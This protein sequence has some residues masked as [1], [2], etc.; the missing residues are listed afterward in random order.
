MATPIGHIEKEVIFNAVHEEKIPVL[1]LKDRV[2][3]TLILESPAG[4]ELT[5]RPD[6]SVGK[7]K[8]HS[9]LS[10]LVNYHGQ[11]VDFAVE[12]MAQNNDTLVCRSP[13]VLHKNLD[14]NYIRVDAPADLKI[15]FTFQGDRYDLSLP[16]INEYENVTAEDM[17]RGMDP[18]NLSGLVKQITNSMKAFSDGYKIVNFKDKQPETIEEKILS[19]TGK[20]LFIPSTTGSFPK[21]DPYPKKRL[22]TEEIFKQYLENTGVGKNFLDENVM[23]FL[24]KRADKGIYSDAW[25]PI[26]FQEYV[27]GYIRVWIENKDKPIFNLNVLDSVFQYSKVLAFSLKENGYFEHGR[28]KGETIQSKVLDISVSGLLFAYP[29]GSTQLDALS[30]GTDLKVGIEAPNRTINVVAKIARR[31][32]DRSAGYLGCRFINMVPEDTR[33]LFEYLYGKQMD[34][35]DSSLIAGQV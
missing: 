35:K 14:R 8:L 21:T 33:F 28:V 16:K 10:M 17:I 25:V 3:Y 31:F 13:S 9:K 15:V 5:F 11:V 32:K 34:D 1:F 6:K 20:A 19:E 7:L 26:L 22:I 18:K 2:E 4:E 27:V 23:R 24:K 12:L 30:I 29:L